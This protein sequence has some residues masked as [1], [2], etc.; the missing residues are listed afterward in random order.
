MKLYLVQLLYFQTSDTYQ[1]FRVSLT[2]A[3]RLIVVSS[4]LEQAPLVGY[5]EFGLESRADVWR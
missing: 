2:Y 3:Y 4:V 5:D 1:S